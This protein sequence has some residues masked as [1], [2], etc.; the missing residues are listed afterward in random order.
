[1]CERLEESA[2]VMVRRSCW[3]R[4]RDA[5]AMMT[6]SFVAFIFIGNERRA[7]QTEMTS[8]V[9]GMH[10]SSGVKFSSAIN[11][12]TRFSFL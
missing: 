9:E 10:S 8:N 5:R 12:L 7:E 6:M 3:V 11:A 2:L 1:M 4:L